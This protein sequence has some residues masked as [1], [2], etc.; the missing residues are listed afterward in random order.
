MIYVT[1]GGL[2]HT[3]EC[4]G[5]AIL[6]LGKICSSF[7]RK[8]GVDDL[9]LGNMIV[10]DIGR[11]YNPVLNQFD[12]HQTYLKRDDG[13]PYASAGLIWKKY[14]LLIVSNF[15]DTNIELVAKRVDD[16]LFKYI[17]AG[18]ASNEFK[19]SAACEAGS[20][21]IYGLHDIVRSMNYL[22][23]NNTEMQAV[24][25]KLAADFL[26]LILKSE[27]IKAIQYFKNV[28][29]FEE[30]IALFHSKEI[31]VLSKS[32]DWK[33][34]VRQNYPDVRFVIANS[35]HP[36][37]AF[38]MIAV[39]VDETTREVYIPIKRSSEFKDFIHLGKWIAGSDDVNSLIKLAEYNISHSCI[40]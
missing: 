39:T 9:P 7:Y 36:N 4:M 26:E 29:T 20:L 11:Q 14:G 6:R 38:N 33:E 34:I 21:T 35:S 10:A 23:T 40:I 15:T 19:Q 28:E 27:I 1:H 17:D 8:R 32:I 13:Y 31:M 2:F 16:K 5:Y 37:S 3:D 24:Q 25:F 18:D 30:N 12:H 22:D